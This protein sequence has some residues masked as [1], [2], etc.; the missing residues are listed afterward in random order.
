[1]S[2]FNKQDRIEMV[3]EASSKL[4]EVIELLE[5]AVEDTYVEASY[6]TYLITHLKSW[7]DPSMYLTSD[8]GLTNLMDWLHNEYEEDC[9]E[10]E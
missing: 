6:K 4:Q 1:M 9:D 5:Q 2:H 10:E 8:Q 3:E 7:R